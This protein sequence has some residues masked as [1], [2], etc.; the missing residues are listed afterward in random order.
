MKDYRYEINELSDYIADRSFT[1]A[2][3]WLEK[4]GVSGDLAIFVI[5]SLQSLEVAR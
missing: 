3:E 5:A 1:E 4:R 2:A